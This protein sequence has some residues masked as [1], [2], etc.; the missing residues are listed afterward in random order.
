MPEESTPL[1][2]SAWLSGGVAAVTGAGSGIGRALAQ[3]FAAEG[4]S[5]ALADVDETA[6][7][8]AAAELRESGAE[9]QAFTVDV[10]SSDEVERFASEVVERF[11]RVNIICNNAGVSGGGL[12]WAITRNDWDWIVA[13]NLMGVVN[14][15]RSFVPRIIAAGGGHVVNTASMA[16]LFAPPFMAPYAATKHAVV[17]LTESLYH[18][19]SMV[20][21]AVGASAL[22][23]GWVKTNILD[24]EAHRPE[25]FAQAEPQADDA[26]AEAL[27]VG[28]RDFVEGLIAKGMEPSDVAAMVWDA[29]GERRLWV[30]THE[31]WLGALGPRTEEMVNGRNP[32]GSL[33]AAMGIE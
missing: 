25:R 5:V 6:V 21:P 1:D 4:L 33:L 19:L 22:C 13:V 20:A 7:E 9:A 24:A 15:I 8:Q 18:E 10:S 17:G 31:A 14:G 28:A 27:G 12:S 26:A 3:R 29:I 16:G 11:G 32:E 2:P 30:F 23:P